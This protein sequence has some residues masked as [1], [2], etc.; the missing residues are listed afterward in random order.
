[1]ASLQPYK[2]TR[3]DLEVIREKLIKEPTF[4]SYND[5]DLNHVADVLQKAFEYLKEIRRQD[6]NF[7]VEENK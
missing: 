4:N 3:V 7:E 2:I 5:K 6:V 1:M